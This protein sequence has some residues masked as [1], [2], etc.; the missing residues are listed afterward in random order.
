MGR[1]WRLLWQ[2]PFSRALTS[3][4]PLL[5]IGLLC[6]IFS[7]GLARDLKVGLVDLDRSALFC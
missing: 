5:L 7:A 6:W 2:D 3:W 1:E 4:I